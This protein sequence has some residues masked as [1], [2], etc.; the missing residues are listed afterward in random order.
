MPH[1]LRTVHLAFTDGDKPQT[2]G[3]LKPERGQHRIRHAG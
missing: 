1:K 3:E 2:P